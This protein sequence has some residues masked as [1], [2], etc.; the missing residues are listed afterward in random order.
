MKQDHQL[1]DF[2]DE[3]ISVAQSA[4]TSDWLL[5]QYKGWIED[6]GYTLV[7]DE[8]PGNV[9]YFNQPFTVFRGVDAVN[10]VT[11][12]LAEVSAF[13]PTPVEGGVQWVAVQVRLLQTKAE[14]SN[15]DLQEQAQRVL[16]SGFS[17]HVRLDDPPARGL[18]PLYTQALSQ[19]DGQL[20]IRLSLTGRERNSGAV[21]FIPEGTPED[22]KS[23][24]VS[25]LKTGSAC[26]AQA[27][28]SRSSFLLELKSVLNETS[29]A[30]L[31]HGK[32]FERELIAQVE[33]G[34]VPTSA[35]WTVQHV[36]EKTLLAKGTEVC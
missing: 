35:V 19:S 18:L 20:G 26:G 16:G 5:E 30:Y 27:L 13:V 36:Y 1:A 9:L 29:A 10:L 4:P 25:L 6:K 2:P 3:I 21:P 8:V 33:R 14:S 32:A 17:T 34:E 22:V 15:L 28:K 11:T 23:V 24:V 7:N 12:P 31:E